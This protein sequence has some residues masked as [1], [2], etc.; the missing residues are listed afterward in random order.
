L[1]LRADGEVL[2]SRYGLRFHSREWIPLTLI[3]HDQRLGL[4]R[5]GSTDQQVLPRLKVRDLTFFLRGG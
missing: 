4:G 2:A 3:V 5:A 1:L